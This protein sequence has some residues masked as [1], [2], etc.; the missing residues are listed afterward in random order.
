M[1]GT[2]Q[3]EEEYSSAAS[4]QA[5]QQAQQVQQ[6]Q[7]EALQ[8]AGLV[9]APSRSMEGQWHAER[10]EEEDLQEGQVG[11]VQVRS[12]L[13]LQAPEPRPEVLAKALAGGQE[14]DEDSLAQAQ[15]G[16]QELQEAAQELLQVP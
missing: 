12:S 7:E 1:S 8:A 6:V 2:G 4:Q 11:Q 15:L 16:D 5:H 14:L 9:H 10:H 13:P 3:V